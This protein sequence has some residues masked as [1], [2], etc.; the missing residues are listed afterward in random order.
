MAGAERLG[1]AFRHGAALRQLVRRLEYIIYLHELFGGVADALAECVEQILF[2][3]KYHAAEA[4]LPRIVD[5]IVHD[6]LS[7]RADRIDLLQTAVAGAHAG[8]HN[9]KNRIC[10]DKNSSFNSCFAQEVCIYYTL[11]FVCLQ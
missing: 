1:A 11:F 8:S 10:H 5:G 7:V 2:Y 9:D 4:S 6:D 3:N